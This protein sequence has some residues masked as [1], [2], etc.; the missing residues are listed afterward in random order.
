MSRKKRRQSARLD[1]YDESYYG[2]ESDDDAYG[3]EDDYDESEKEWD[4][5]DDEDYDEDDE[6]YEKSPPHRRQK[7]VSFQS[8][9]PRKTA[10]FARSIGIRE[11]KRKKLPQSSMIRAVA[12]RPKSSPHAS[13][14]WRYHNA[15]T[16]YERSKKF[17]KEKYGE[18]TPRKPHFWSIFPSRPQEQYVNSKNEKYNNAHDSDVSDRNEENAAPKGGTVSAWV[19]FLFLLLA[20]AGGTWY[21]FHVS[22][23]PPSDNVAKPASQKNGKS[24]NESK[25][26]TQRIANRR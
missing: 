26:S 14:R 12:H 11:S 25:I 21:A 8:R 16:S 20:L 4:E 9:P 23:L 13:N 10:T 24:E 6:E 5:E 19:K 3:N 7:P 17:G 2:D 22:A 1:D 15:E 18:E